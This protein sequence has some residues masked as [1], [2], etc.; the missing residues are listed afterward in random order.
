M[1]T[2]KLRVSCKVTGALSGFRLT[3][4]ENGSI[5]DFKDRP[6]KELITYIYIFIFSQ[7]SIFNFH[8]TWLV[9]R[10]FGIKSDITEGME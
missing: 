1:E 9:F 2:C 6:K 3:I 7:V 10:I 4:Q 8:L 5:H